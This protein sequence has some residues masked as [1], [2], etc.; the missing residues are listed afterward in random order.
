MHQLIKTYPAEHSRTSVFSRMQNSGVLQLHVTNEGGSRCF[1]RIRAI[2][3]SYKSYH[4]FAIH[5]SG[6]LFSAGADGTLKVRQLSSDE[7]NVA[8]ESMGA[9][10]SVTFSL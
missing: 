3:V 4:S 10:K 7:S 2:A 9:S 5:F 8:H 6:N 1:T